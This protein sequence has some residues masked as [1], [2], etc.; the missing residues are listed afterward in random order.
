MLHSAIDH[1]ASAKVLFYSNSRCFDSA[2]YLSHLG[3]ELVLKA[4][5]LNK[6]NSFPAEHSLS[7]LS[8]LIKEQGINLNYT[9]TH[10]K[11][12]TSLDGFYELRYPKALNHIEVGDDDWNN[13]ESLFEYLIFM[14]PDRLQQ[15]LRQINYLGKGNRI[16]MRKKKNI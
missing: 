9:S 14:L 7:K 12:L 13:I 5:L 8:L 16:L 1:L 6:T 10:D 4:L 2:G 15:E 3:I 11:T